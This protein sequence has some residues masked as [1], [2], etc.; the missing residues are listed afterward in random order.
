MRGARGLAGGGAG[1]IAVYHIVVAVI[2]VPLIRTPLGIVRQLVLRV[3]DVAV[4]GAELLAELRS[5]GGADLD[6]LAAGDALFLIDVR[7]VSAAGHVGSIEELG[8]TQG[9]ADAGRAVADGEN[10]ILAVDIGYLVNIAL[11][12]GTL[13]NLHGLV[14][15]DEP[16]VFLGLVAVKG[17]VADRDAPQILD[18]TRA[19]AAHALRAAAGA[20]ADSKLIILLQPV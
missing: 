3:L 1:V 9:V 16:A 10:L 6:A 8:G 14:I 13:E 11:I 15:G 2:G 19:F 18:V 4:L 17:S 7:D 12:L 20:D 5:T